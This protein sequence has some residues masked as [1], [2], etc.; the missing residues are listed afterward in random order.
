MSINNIKRLSLNPHFYSLLMQSFL[1]GYENP[2]EIK[3]PFM[4]IPILLYAESRE[5][6]VNANKRSRIDT[7]FQS[8][9]TINENKISGRT[10]LSG[11]V[12]RYNSLKPY[13]KEA[14]I[15]L[16]SEQKITISN[17]KIVLIKNINYKDF[18]GT[19]K[20]WIK[21]AFYLGVVFSKTTEDH[22]SFF[23]GVDTK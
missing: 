5:K 10:R 19:I 8:P 21:C 23:L 12:E 20:E 16:S 13:C 2:C 11:Y 9:Q 14:I 18:Q 6:L 22:L 7:L 4:A 1:S 3:L 15:I 17:H